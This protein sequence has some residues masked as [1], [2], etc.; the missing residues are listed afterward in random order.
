VHGHARLGLPLEEGV[1]Q[2]LVVDVN[3]AQLG[4][5]LIL[6]QQ[7]TCLASL[8]SIFKMNLEETVD[9]KTE[10]S[11]LYITSKM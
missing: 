1:V 9:I 8:R 7:K 6:Q 4:S 10:I 3:L 11:S 5:H 2:L